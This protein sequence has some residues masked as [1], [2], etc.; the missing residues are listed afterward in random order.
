[1]ELAPPHRHFMVD[2]SDFRVTPG[3]RENGTVAGQ[4]TR[5][6]S[7]RRLQPMRCSIITLLVQQSSLRASTRASPV[8]ADS[9]KLCCYIILSRLFINRQIAT[10]VRREPTTY[11]IGKSVR[12]ENSATPS[13]RSSR[14]GFENCW[15]TPSCWWETGRWR[16]KIF[17]RTLPSQ[18]R[19]PRGDLLPRPISSYDKPVKIAPG[20]ITFSTTDRSSAARWGKPFETSMA[21]KE[22]MPR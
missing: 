18:R 3:Q 17:V 21:K 19:G 15:K 1:M 8:R 12:F 4:Y 9:Q 6:T 7:S 20:R 14:I 13:S 16:L 11:R 10:L 5:N 22:A 2:A